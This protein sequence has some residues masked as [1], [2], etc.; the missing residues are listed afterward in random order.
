MNRRSSGTRPADTEI[1]AVVWPCTSPVCRCTRCLATAIDLVAALV[2]DV[3]LK[4][5]FVLTQGRA[6]AKCDSSPAGRNSEPAE[7]KE[8]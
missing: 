3:I 1:E 5:E 2:T 7:D 8:A 4:T 6:Y